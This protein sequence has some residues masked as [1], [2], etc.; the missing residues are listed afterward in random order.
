[1]LHRYDAA[2]LLLI[3]QPS[4][5]WISGQLAS[6]WGNPENGF[7]SAGAELR[8]AAEQ[9]DIAWLDWEA[10]PTLNRETGLPHTFSQLP[11][12]EHLEVWS[13]A[14]SRALSYGRLPALLISM[15]GTYLYERFHDYE[16][17]TSEEASAARAFLQRELEVQGGLMEQLADR[18]DISHDSF[19]FQRRLVSL[20]DAM[21][22]ALGMGVEEDREFRDVPAQDD[23]TVLAVRRNSPAD[24]E[25]KVEPWPFASDRVDLYC[26]GR[27]LD[28]VFDDE[29]AMRVA[30]ANAPSEQLRLSL[31]R[32]N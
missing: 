9:H 29:K 21:S 28:G 13:N 22:L 14:T 12:L 1:M 6:S 25:F 15:H 30:I 16:S 20:W 17:D 31:V 10:R 4:H 8:I 3:S 18:S 7:D 26:E 23:D 11:T 19:T 32:G 5:A 2:G 24:D 27:R